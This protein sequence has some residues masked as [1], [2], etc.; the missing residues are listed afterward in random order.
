MLENMEARTVYALASTLAIVRERVS[1]G[2]L[3]GP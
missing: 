1:G 3:V 2:L